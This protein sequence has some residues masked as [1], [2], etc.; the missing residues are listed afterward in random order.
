V[1]P[2]L[3]AP[4]WDHIYVTSSHGHVWPCRGRSLGGLQICAGVGNTDQA[5]CL[6]QP[7]SEAG[8]SFGKTG[9]CHQMANRILLPSGLTVS[10]S[11]GYRLS[12]FAYGVY[13]LD[14]ATLGNSLSVRISGG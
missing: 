4:F 7:N 1:L 13:G 12:T 11:H 6:S 8:V 2:A 3:A 10:S 5:D 9:V 14:L